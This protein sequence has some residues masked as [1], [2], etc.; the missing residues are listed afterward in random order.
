MTD[1]RG[2]NRRNTAYNINLRDVA[3]V[4]SKLE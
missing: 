2:Q 1:M 3:Q 4:S